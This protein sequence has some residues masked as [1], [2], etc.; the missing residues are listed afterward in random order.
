[1]IALVSELSKSIPKTRPDLSQK[2]DSR[3]R[4]STSRNNK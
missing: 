1:M 2:V 3:N 4:K